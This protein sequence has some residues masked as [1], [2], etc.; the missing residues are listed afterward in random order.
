MDSSVSDN[1]KIAEVSVENIELHAPPTFSE[2]GVDLHEP[3]LEPE[4]SDS[5]LRAAIYRLM[6]L[7]VHDHCQT[8]HD[9]VCTDLY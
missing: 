3:L 6:M 4:S 5:E 2:V 9:I 1:E 7:L 8:R